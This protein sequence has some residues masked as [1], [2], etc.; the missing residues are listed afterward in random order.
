MLSKNPLSSFLQL[1]NHATD[2][3]NTQIVT[4]IEKTQEIQ[5]IFLEKLPQTSNDSASVGAAATPL[6]SSPYG[7]GV[8]PGP[9]TAA[10][11]SSSAS[12]SPVISPDKPGL[13]RAVDW[14]QEFATKPKGLQFIAKDAGASVDYIGKIVDTTKLNNELVNIYTGGTKKFRH[15]EPALLAK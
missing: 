2:F 6:H 12:P 11:S 8:A 10:T 3:P 4:D 5:Q 1:I 15:H 9:A 14:A 7:A 13:I